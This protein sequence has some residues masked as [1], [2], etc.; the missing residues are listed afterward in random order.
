MSDRVILLVEDNKDDELLALRAFKRNNISHDVVVVHDGVEA[1]DYLFGTGAYAG[2]D[3]SDV[4]QLVLLD[5][6]LPRLC[7]LDVLRRIRGDVRTQ[8]VT[9]VMLTSSRE[10]ED[11]VRSY[12]LGAN[13]FVRKPVDF[14][15]FAMAVKTLD[16]YWLRLNEA[17]PEPA[18]S[19]R[20]GSPTRSA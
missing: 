10:E 16:L 19:S 4:P 5:I 12:S 15:Q 14:E 2:R 20:A 1:A 17:A 3:P 11:V 13:S 8:L 6:N 9:V 7:G 18:R